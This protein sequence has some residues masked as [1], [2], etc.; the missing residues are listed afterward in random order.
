MGLRSDLKEVTDVELVVAMHFSQGGR[1]EHY[2]NKSWKNYP[3]IFL[4]RDKDSFKNVLQMNTSVKAQQS[5]LIQ[6]SLIPISNSMALSH[7]KY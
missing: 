3:D 7:L 6:S 5:A 2:N 1:N 4:L